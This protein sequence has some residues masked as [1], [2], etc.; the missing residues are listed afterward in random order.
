M[1][2]T[3]QL[4]VPYKNNIPKRTGESVTCNEFCIVARI[5]SISIATLEVREWI[6]SLDVC[7]RDQLPT[8]T[9][10]YKTACDAAIRFADTGVLEIGNKGVGRGR[11]KK[12]LDQNITKELRTIVDYAIKQEVPTSAGRIGNELREKGIEKSVRTITRHLHAEGYFWG[13]GTRQHVMHDAPANVMYRQRYLQQRFENLIE[14]DRKIVPA[15]PEVFLDE[16]YCHLNSSTQRRVPSDGIV[17]DQGRQSLVVM[18]A[19]F[20]VYCDY[21]ARLMEGKFVN[22]SVHIWPSIGKALLR[23]RDEDADLCNNALCQAG[24]IATDDD[25]HGNF[26]A[27]VFNII[28]VPTRNPTRPANSRLTSGKQLRHSSFIER[29]KTRT[30]KSRATSSSSTRKEGSFKRASIQH[31]VNVSLVLA[32]YVLGE[33][34]GE[35][36]LQQH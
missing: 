14:V 6:K 1:V 33:V 5:F 22:D 27:D 4:I 23:K 11:K 12:A 31:S 30:D 20:V 26:N 19:A 21:E 2:S 32:A 25:Y 13:K 29:R 16:S 28:T 9:G 8:L 35:K 36:Q 7:P 24:V 17:A 34:Q 3:I 15:Y 10:L 18:F